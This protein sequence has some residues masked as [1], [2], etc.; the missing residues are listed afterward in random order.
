MAGTI[1][2]EKLGVPGVFINC[3]TFNDDAM[4]AAS[5]NAMPA[6]RNTIIKSSEF[7]RVRATV[8]LIRPMVAGIF[9][10]LV[11]KMTK[12]LTAEEASPPQAGNET[13]GPPTA[14]VTADSYEAV[15]EE[16]NQ[17]YLGKRWGDG[18][19]LVPPTAER[20]Q[21]MLSGTRRSPQEKLGTIKPKQ[22]VATVEKVAVNAVMAGASPEYFP[23]ILAVMDAITDP[24]YDD[25][26]ML[27]S[28]G[29]FGLM[30]VV[31]GPIVK[32]IGMYGGI[33]YL[34]HGFRA[35]NTIGRA[36]RLATLNIGRT[37]PGVND[38]S[39]T[40]RLQ[41]H[42]FFTFPENYAD[43]AWEPYHASRGYDAG[44]SC[45]TVANIFNAGPM[46]SFF[47]GI[48]G[49]WNA[50]DVMD[51]MVEAI[52]RSNRMMF[53]QWGSKGV[54]SNPGSGGGSNNHMIMLFP[55]LAAEY[56]KMGF[57]QTALQNEIYNRA[58][59]PYEEL[60]ERD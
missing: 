38:M 14:S 48:I 11:E 19:P 22:G 57:D 29:S 46:Q 17:V 28:A 59:V 53:G 35:N 33:G 50:N 47:G 34:G 32:E 18:L 54:G 12:P 41:P 44:D 26:H 60:Q 2:F 43:S 7:Y 23:V 52:V 56:K 16:F 15:F 1:K 25:L 24:D 30:I 45:V 27:A 40:G 5:D 8:D 39:L 9:D 20:V 21:W 58:V 36:V 49:T 31:S 4:S 13:D 37:W 42:T 6:V 3:D 10:E 55:S 51:R